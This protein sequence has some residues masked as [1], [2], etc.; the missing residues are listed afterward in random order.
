[1]YGA[2]VVWWFIYW[3]RPEHG[4]SALGAQRWAFESVELA[5]E[6]G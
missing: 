2:A 3:S 1:M 4:L 5:I 6:E